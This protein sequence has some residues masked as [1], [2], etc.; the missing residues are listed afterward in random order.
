MWGA[1]DAAMRTARVPWRCGFLSV[2]AG[3]LQIAVD[4]GCRQGVQAR[5]HADLLL[6][7]NAGEWRR[8]CARAVLRAGVEVVNSHKSAGLVSTT[9]RPTA[10]PPPHRLQFNPDLEMTKCGV[11]AEWYHNRCVQDDLGSLPAVPYTCETCAQ[12]GGGSGGDA[13]P[14]VAGGEGVS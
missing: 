4:A 11:C 2:G 8:I 1:R 5:P 6:L 9:P 14:C 13:A 10:P 3:N 7:P 12:Q